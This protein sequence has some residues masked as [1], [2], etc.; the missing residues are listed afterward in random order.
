MPNDARNQLEYPIKRIL[1][2]HSVHN[3]LVSTEELSQLI[4][5]PLEGIE[6]DV[7][8]YEGVPVVAHD[9]EDAKRGEPLSV[10]LPI[11]AQSDKFLLLE[12]KE[13]S[14]ELWNAV[15]HVVLS[16]HFESRTTIFAF[17]DIAQQFPW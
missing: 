16:N 17:P 11:I 7:R 2:G 15:I 3:G 8:S 10:L 1:H 4:T 13:Y 9:R 6:L 12:L 5:L 14:R